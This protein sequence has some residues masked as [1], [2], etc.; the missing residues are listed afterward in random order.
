MACFAKGTEEHAFVFREVN[1]A[2]Q[3]GLL[4]RGSRS[5]VVTE[6]TIYLPSLF[7]AQ[8]SLE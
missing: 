5:A 4:Q 7:L 2:A 6:T 8:E 1:F 3:A